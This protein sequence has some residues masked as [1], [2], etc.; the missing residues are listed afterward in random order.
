M[1]K[2][3]FKDELSFGEGKKKKE[4]KEKKTF[5]SLHLVF[6]SLSSNLYSVS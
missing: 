5:W 1:K 6:Y 2:N 3:H 4:K